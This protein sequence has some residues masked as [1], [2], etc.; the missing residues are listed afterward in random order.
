MSNL[1]DYLKALQTATTPE[2]QA[3]LEKHLGNYL[4]EVNAENEKTEQQR[5]AE[6][7]LTE[8]AQLSQQ[9]EKYSNNPGQYF[10]QMQSAM[11]RIDE[12]QNRLV[13]I[14]AVQEPRN[15]Q[16]NYIVTS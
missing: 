13:E 14:G 15:I 9:Y 2:R 8:Q 12:I 3:A 5:E 11:S 1:S 7:L 16:H 4:S 6:T 10:T